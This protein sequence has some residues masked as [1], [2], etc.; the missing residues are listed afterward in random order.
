MLSKNFMHIISYFAPWF[1]LLSQ[2]KPFI[3]L[4]FIRTLVSFYP[5]KKFIP[6]FSFAPWFLFYP[7]KNFIHYFSFAPWLSFYP[8][9]FIHH[10]SFAPWLSFLCHQ[11]FIHKCTFI[12]LH[13]TLKILNFFLTSIS[14]YTYICEL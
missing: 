2:T 3:N 4:I 12:I 11:I 14:S 5:K 8:K 13:N 6:H 10:F 9:K 7:K 1:S